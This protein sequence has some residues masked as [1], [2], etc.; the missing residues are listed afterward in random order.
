ME[1]YSLLTHVPKY[2][3]PMSCPSIFCFVS[4]HLFS[5]IGIQR[6]RLYSYSLLVKRYAWVSQLDSTSGVLLT[7]RTAV[8]TVTRFAQLHREKFT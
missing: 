2:I 3:L 5:Q 1:A 8:N 4:R 7:K 6:I